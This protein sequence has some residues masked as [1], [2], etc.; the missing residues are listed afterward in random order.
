MICLDFKYASV[1]YQQ[2]YFWVSDRIALPTL[3]VWVS[4]ERSQIK[5]SVLALGIL[6]G[7]P[8]PR[9]FAAHSV[10][11]DKDHVISSTC[12]SQGNPA[13]YAAGCTCNDCNGLFSVD[14]DTVKRDLRSSLQ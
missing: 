7:D 6:C 4:S 10:T 14:S 11:T 5:N 2:G 13:A 1:I 8:A 12:Q 3:W 9:R